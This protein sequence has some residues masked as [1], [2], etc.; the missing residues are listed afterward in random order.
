[1][2]KKIISLFISAMIA[3]C[4]ISICV[5]EGNENILFDTAQQLS[6]F[7]PTNTDT[8]LN[9][10]VLEC[11]IKDD[12]RSGIRTASKFNL[13]DYD[14]V[15]IRLSYENIDNPSSK[16]LEYEG[17]I[18]P[19]LRL[20]LKV[21]DSRNTMSNKFLDIFAEE[22]ISSG[23]YSTD[24]YVM[25]YGN[26][27][28]IPGYDTEQYT[29]YSITV[30]PAYGFSAGKAYIDMIELE[31]TSAVN[32]QP[33]I[34]QASSDE[35]W[36]CDEF[37]TDNCGWTTI[38]GAAMT[39]TNGS[40]QYVSTFNAKNQTGWIQKNV[41]FDGQQYC[42][43]DIRVK[44]EGVSLTPSGGTPYLAIYYTGIGS[45]G[46][47]ASHS[48]S[49]K[50][51]MSYK[52]EK[53]TDGLYYSD[54]VEYSVDLSSLKGWDTMKSISQF[55]IDVIKN[56]EGTVSIDYIRLFSMPV[57]TEVGYNGQTDKDLQKVP[58]DIK[59]LEIYLSQPIY[60]VDADSVKIYSLD[61]A[62]ADIQSVIYDKEKGIVTVNLKEELLSMTDYC[63]EITKDALA[64][65]A[66]K[67]YKELVYP[68]KTEEAKLEVNVKKANRSTVTM[69]VVNND[70]KSRKILL[71]V[72]GWNG[73]EYADKI[74]TEINVEP[75]TDIDK[76][77][78]IKNLKGQNAEVTA[79]EFV[80]DKPL[81]LG[82]SVYKFN[83]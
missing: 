65:S 14:N 67:L 78:N 74:V 45:D 24:G 41:S 22:L 61:G 62:L 12:E 25:M 56:A 76:Q 34:P 63:I 29:V 32:V 11:E 2:N 40:M 43:L 44:V 60:S 21:I 13:K 59:S 18:V 10:D 57:I 54:W 46:V 5:A 33:D 68:F 16:A 52:C 64:G 53:D 48:D 50:L 1:M 71:I 35:E 42:R 70:I 83:K 31:K 39:I 3:L 6:D 58:V 69:S 75:G 8:R 36:F 80:S 30:Y 82:K 20:G 19:A 49:R 51:E 38:N 37:D 47:S 77:I 17:N 7:V 15:N 66:L 73:D 4:N 26:L 72:T 9:G 28:D 27:S 55:R 79:W 23:G 81:V